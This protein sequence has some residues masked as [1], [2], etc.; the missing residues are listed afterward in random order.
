MLNQYA[1]YQ[2]CPEKAVRSLQFR[3]YEYL[4]EHH[5]QVNADNYRQVYFSTLLSHETVEGIR[6]KLERKLPRSFT[7]R[8][9]S[10]SDIIAVTRDGISS[11]YYVDPE[12]LVLLAGFFRSSSSS[13]LISLETVNYVIDGRKGTWM[14]ADEEVVDGRHFFLMQSELYGNNAKFAVVDEAG[15]PAASDTKDGFDEITLR[16]IRET[17]QKE[18]QEKELKRNLTDRPE[19]EI[20]EKYL[21]NGEYFRSLETTTE[22]G[23]SFIDGRVNN[24]SEKA[25]KEHLKSEQEQLQKERTGSAAKEQP[26]PKIP[27]MSPMKVK[28]MEQRVSV[29]KRLREKQAQIAGNHGVP[30]PEQMLTEELQR[31]RK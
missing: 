26:E 19:K 15:K 2:L 13:S 23:Y 22:D 29:L 6:Q 11:A 25:R 21:E 31:N 4:M 14:A 8:A 30:L 17:I 12:K 10:V 16:Q 1:V 9:L 24:L 5:L 20:W 3:S 18:L 28:P 27:G 7:G